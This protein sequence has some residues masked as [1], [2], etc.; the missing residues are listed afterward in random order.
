MVIGI[1]VMVKMVW[2]VERFN[3][4]NRQLL[5]MVVTCGS[6]SSS[7]QQ[8]MLSINS[9]YSIPI[10]IDFR[11][12]WPA[13]IG[14]FTHCHWPRCNRFWRL[15]KRISRRVRCQM[16]NSFSLLIR[17]LLVHGVD[18]WKKTESPKSRDSVPLK[19]NK[20]NALNSNYFKNRVMS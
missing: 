20:I 6:A 12:S 13:L 2:M 1:L 10:Y 3:E 5:V 14:T 9:I 16:R 18:W 4:V 15:S 8:D 11:H 19:T 7:L 17:D